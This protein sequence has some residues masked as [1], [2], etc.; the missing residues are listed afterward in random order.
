M[1][2]LSA[3]LLTGLLALVVGGTAMAATSPA[4]AAAAGGTC[5][6]APQF[7]TFP[8]WYRGLNV[9]D[10]CDVSVDAVGGDLSAFIWVIVLNVIDIA[11]NVVGYVAA[12]FIIYGGFLLMTANG[13]PDKITK[14]RVTI[15]DAAIG[16][17]I[18]FASVAAVN[19]IVNN[20][21]K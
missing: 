13:V 4:T 12:G 2:K 8:V 20:V 3:F 16:L 14:A 9:G 6:S 7:L 21:I 19:L 10:N 5:S 15:R 18:S 11:L 17:I 1:K